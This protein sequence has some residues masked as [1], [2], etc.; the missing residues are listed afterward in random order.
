ADFASV[1]THA[2]A[3][4]AHI[5]DPQVLLAEA[6]TGTGKTLGYLAPASVWAEQND[7]AVWISTY[8]KH[9]QRQIE[10]ETTRLHADDTVRRQHVVV[11]KGRENY[12]CLLNME[13]WVN[14]VLN[15]G[16]DAS[17][18]ALITLCLIARW[19]TASRDGDLMGGDL[20]GWFGDLMGAGQ[21][22]AL[23]DRR[24]ECIHGACPHYQRCFVEHSIRRARHADLVIANHALVMAQAAWAS[25]A[26][27]ADLPVEQ[28]DNTPTRY[29]FDE[30]HHIA[31]AAD[32]AFATEFS[33][34][35]AAELRRW[36]LGAEGGRS[37][38]R[39]LRRRLDDLVVGFKRL[40]EPL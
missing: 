27:I 35:E 21:V 9:L 38:A 39:G 19:A 13:D 33:G 6:G 1:A 18:G 32:G 36:L 26:G 37:R 25:P 31:D 14:T 11:R 34:L 17:P 7:G 22:A 5:G 10:A 20:P 12:L 24:G 23:A 15:R 30:G 29:V 8:T 16:R 28:E 4:R 40:E 3:P 2:F